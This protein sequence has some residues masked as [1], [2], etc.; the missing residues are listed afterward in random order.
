MFIYRSKFENDFHSYLFGDMKRRVENVDA[1]LIFENIIYSKSKVWEFFQIKIYFF[2]LIKIATSEVFTHL[3]E[4]L[5]Y[6]NLE[7]KI[8]SIKVSAAAIS[9]CLEKFK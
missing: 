8:K 3:L 4:S 5:I 9:A 2:V 6:N 1:K 7:T